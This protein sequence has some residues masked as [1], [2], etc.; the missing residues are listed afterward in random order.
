MAGPGTG[1]LEAMIDHDNLEEFADPR[2]YDI[3]EGTATEPAARFYGDLAE[4]VGGPVLEIACGT[5]LVTLPVAARG[6]DI[7]GTDISRTML[8]HARRKAASHA[9]DIDW[10]EGDALTLALGRRFELVYLTGNAFQ[11]FLTDADQDALM[12]SVARHLVAGGVLAFETRNPSS[13]D[14]VDRPEESPWNRYVDA[15]GDV[16]TV[17]GTQRYDAGARIMHWT[18]Y[19]R[20][21]TGGEPH[22][23]VSRIACR[24]T[25]ADELRARLSAH[26]FVVEACH[27]DFDRRVLDDRALSIV[28]ICRYRPTAARSPSGRATRAETSGRKPAR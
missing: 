18:T 11:A 26:G 12:D 28:I 10:I 4:R 8:D 25:D 7:A 20:R 22:C 27:G 14:L 2:N 17:S 13:H 16:V 15:D 6:V 21:T 24:F 23:R 5:G 1:D 3:E 9:L 19:R